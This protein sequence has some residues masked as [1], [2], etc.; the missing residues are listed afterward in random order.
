VLSITPPNTTAVLP[1]AALVPPNTAPKL[2]KTALVSTNTAPAGECDDDDDD[3][4]DEEEEEETEAEAA[5][6]NCAGAVLGAGA[7][8]VTDPSAAAPGTAPSMCA[9]K[10]G[11]ASTLGK[12]GRCEGSFISSDVTR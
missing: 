8:L 12:L 2:P 10:N 3:D 6:S 1:K 4:D 7:A 11:R 5:G 9:C